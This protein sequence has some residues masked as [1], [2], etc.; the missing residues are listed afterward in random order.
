MTKRGSKNPPQGR[1][2]LEKLMSADM[3]AITAQSDRIGRHFA[4]Q[5]EVSGGDFHA[6]LHIMVAETAGKPLTLAQLRERMNVTPAA[7]T[8][9]V[10]RMIEAGHIRRESDPADRRKSLLR[11]EHSG[12]ALAREFFS[13][14]GAHLRAALADLPDKDLI[15]AHRVFMAMITAMSTFE[16]ELHAERPGSS[17]TQRSAAKAN[18]GRKVAR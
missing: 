4:R 2:E 18:R 6:L 8:Y 10:D 7:I 13:P 5:H 11:Y 17:T 9:L 3:R 15:A 16:A 14:L 1:A 12:M